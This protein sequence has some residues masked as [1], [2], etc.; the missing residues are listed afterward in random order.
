MPARDISHET[1][2]KMRGYKTSKDYK[3][4]KE[5][6]DGGYK[7]PAVVHNTWLCMFRH[8]SWYLCGTFI[9]MNA[10]S[11]SAPFDLTCERLHLEFIEPTE[12]VQS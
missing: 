8:G 6:L 7:V 4:L 10:Y 5:L 9:T 2:N 11:P 12:E 1:S 3:R